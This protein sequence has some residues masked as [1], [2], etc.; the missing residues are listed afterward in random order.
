MGGEDDTSSMKEKD[1][2]SKESLSEK[3]GA[4][5]KRALRQL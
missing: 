3:V 2:T 5:N 1:G 4:S